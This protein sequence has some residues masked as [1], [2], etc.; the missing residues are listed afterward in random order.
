[1]CACS[2]REPLGNT[3]RKNWGIH[4]AAFLSRQPLVKGERLVRYE[5]NAVI[6]EFWDRFWDRFSGVMLVVLENRRVSSRMGM[7][8]KAQKGPKNQKNKKGQQKEQ[9]ARPDYMRGCMLKRLP[10]RVCRTWRSAM[11]GQ[12]VRCPRASSRNNLPREKLAW[13]AIFRLEEY[14]LSHW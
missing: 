13:Q 3:P 8:P 9:K 10:L 1:M 4:I 6:S 7:G 2:C 5:V 11:P 14:Q 12:H